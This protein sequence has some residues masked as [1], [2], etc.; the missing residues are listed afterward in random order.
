MIPWV[1]FRCKQQTQDASLQAKVN[2]LSA[3][4][5]FPVGTSGTTSYTTPLSPAMRKSR[6]NK[7]YNSNISDSAEF[8]SVARGERSVP[9]NGLYSGAHSRLYN[10][11]AH[12]KR[13][14]H[15]DQAINVWARNQYLMSMTPATADLHPFVR[16]P[17]AIG[18]EHIIPGYILTAIPS[19]I[20]GLEQFRNGRSSR[21]F[22]T[23]GRA[24]LGSEERAWVQ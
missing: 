24:Y 8:P 13:P 12:R 1:D 15:R 16:I 20:D 7:N 10:S 17:D 11:Y 19:G 9:L 21:A 2:S 3:K 23:Y 22:V 5:K 4:L 18:A 14:A 6:P